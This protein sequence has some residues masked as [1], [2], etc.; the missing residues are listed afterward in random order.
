MVASGNYF[1]GAIWPFILSF[2]EIFS[3]WRFTYLIFGASCLVIVI[4]SSLLLIAYPPRDDLKCEEYRIK[5]LSVQSFISPR[6]FLMCLGLAAISCCIAMSMPQIHIVA[7]C[8][9]LGFGVSVGT[10]MLSLMLMGGVLSRIVSGLATDKFGAINVLL[11]GSIL[12]CIGLLLYLP[13][14]GLVSLYA[15]SLIFGLAQG[16]IVPSYAV[17]VRQYFSPK[18]AAS[19]VGLV[20]MAT[21][22]GMA[23]GGWLSGWIYDATGSYN[24][25]FLNGIAWNFINISIIFLL[26]FYR[27]LFYRNV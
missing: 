10:E 1:S 19:K 6:I 13:T 3:D 11:V 9:D 14:D 18:Q 26:F 15:V 23:F 16:G 12:Q 21:I 22:I 5:N 4:P 20:M 24:V 25:A 27:R 17:I 8:V 7:L 2:F